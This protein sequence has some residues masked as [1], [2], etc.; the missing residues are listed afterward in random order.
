M[1]ESCLRK[2]L[3]IV[4]AFICEIDVMHDFITLS[5]N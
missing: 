3:L 4:S 5:G 2:V 1:E